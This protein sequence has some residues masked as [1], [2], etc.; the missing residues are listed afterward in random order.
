VGVAGLGLTHTLVA[1]ALFGV[2][3]CLYEVGSTRCIALLRSP[4][5]LLV[6]IGF[7]LLVNGGYPCSSSWYGELCLLIGLSRV[8]LLGS[9]LVVIGGSI[10][11][12]SGMFLW[13]TLCTG[14]VRCGACGAGATCPDRGDAFSLG[15]WLG[16]VSSGVSTVDGT[17]LSTAW[18]G[19]RG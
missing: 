17:L 7:S 10:T 16:G 14:R 13:V 19:S 2:F 12:L 4:A 8:C 6:A 15:P 9:L 1:G 3:A 18:V 11:L 5:G